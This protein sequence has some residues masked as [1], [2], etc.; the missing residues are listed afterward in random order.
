M[1]PYPATALP[2]GVVTCFLF[3]INHKA[4]EE[5]SNFGKRLVSSKHIEMPT[6]QKNITRACCKPSAAGWFFDEDAS[7][8]VD[9]G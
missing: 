4:Q 5:L 3:F 1:V 8:V 6:G 9:L 7:I 2:E